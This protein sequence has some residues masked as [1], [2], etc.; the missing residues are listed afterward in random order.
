MWAW[1][2]EPNRRA[3]RS[4]T[5]FLAPCCATRRAS[6]SRS[7]VNAG[8]TLSST[9]SCAGPS[10]RSHPP[11]RRT[12]YPRS[13]HADLRTRCGDLRWPDF[14]RNVRWRDDLDLETLLSLYY[15]DGFEPTPARAAPKEAPGSPAL[16]GLAKAMSTDLIT[17]LGTYRAQLPV[18]ALTRGLMALINLE[19]YA[20]TIKLA[21]AVDEMVSSGDVPARLRCGNGTGVLT[22][23]STSRARGGVSVTGS[24]ERASSGSSSR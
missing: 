23:T 24:R 19:L 2:V 21:Y 5:S 1:L 8:F 11:R 14:R 3:S 15:L 7:S 17:Y 13:V 10:M 4:S 6:L 20:Y 9:T 22:Y 16:P 12:L 18:L